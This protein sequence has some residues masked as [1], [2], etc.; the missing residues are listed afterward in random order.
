M[1]AVGSDA[2]AEIGTAAHHI[3]ERIDLQ[4]DPGHIPTVLRADVDAY[5]ALVTPRFR[6]VD[7]ERFVVHDPLRVAG[8]LDRAAELLVPMTPTNDDGEPIGDE[9]PAGTVL[10]GDVKTS[11]DMTWAGAKF[12]VQ[13][14]VYATG[15]PYN[16]QTG[17][18]EEWGHPVPSDEWALII[19]APSKQG[20]AALHWVN[21]TDAREA[22][23]E[24]YRVYEWRNSRGKRLISKA[25]VVDAPPEDFFATAREA[26]SISELREAARRAS[27]SG[28][29]NEV[30]QQAFTRRKNEIEDDAAAAEAEVVLARQSGTGQ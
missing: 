9:I 5:R 4:L 11:Q 16:T 25:V 14:F 27:S 20:K 29:W 19:H 2:A 24:S 18:R 3:Y 13:C 28:A 12:G 21:L 1:K 17:Q 6:A 26:T 23:D 8:T 15:T 7:V 30:L 10:L 22:A